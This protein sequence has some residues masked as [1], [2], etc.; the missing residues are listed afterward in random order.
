MLNTQTDIR[1][2]CENSGPNVVLNKYLDADGK[3]KPQYVT[4]DNGIEHD[5]KIAMCLHKWHR[6]NDL[7]LT[8]QQ[9]TM[10]VSNAGN[11]TQLQWDNPVTIMHS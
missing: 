2:W 9:V 3:I 10:R 5:H 11:N 6:D 1:N 8:N 4:A 7:T